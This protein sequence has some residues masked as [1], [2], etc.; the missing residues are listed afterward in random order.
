M[1]A[2]G[3]VSPF[4]GWT[5]RRLRESH[6]HGAAGRVANIADDPVAAFTPTVGEIMTAHGFGLFG[7]P[8]GQL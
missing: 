6:E 7:E 3:G 1:L 2:G 8:V 4:A 5:L